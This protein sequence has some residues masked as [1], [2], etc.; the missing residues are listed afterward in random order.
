MRR[1]PHYIAGIAYGRAMASADRTP[2]KP[3]LP[4]IAQTNGTLRSDGAPGDTVPIVGGSFLMGSD[5][6]YS[7]EAPA[8]RVCVDDFVLDRFPVTNRQFSAF[9]AATGYRTVAERPVDPASIPDANPGML[10]PGSMVFDP[11]RGP[12]DLSDIRNWWSWRPGAYWRH[13]EGR[14]SSVAAR[15]DHPVVH[16]AFEDAEAYARWVGKALPNEAEWEYAAR[17]GLDSA[18]FAWGDEFMPNGR[19]MSNTWQGE[20]P[21]QNR[22]E[23]KLKR[24]SAVGSYPTNGFGVHDMIGNVWE[25]TTDWFSDRHRTDPDNPCCAPDTLR[26]GSI[27]ASYDPS[28]P[29]VRIPRKV[30]KG[31][32]FLC[33]PSYCRRYRPA[34]RHA[35][36]IDSGMSHIG[37]RCILRCN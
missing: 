19:R 31:G 16:I 2:P 13:P 6:H 3:G 14:G 10:E 26:G 17:G 1:S 20:F 5:K 7:E 36:M 35:Q 32:S 4:D 15:L 33:A 28:Q 37:F 18:E 11:P 24:T 25:W 34:A 21:W 27:D 23:H 12:V 30:V 8:H 22:S 9:V 29:D